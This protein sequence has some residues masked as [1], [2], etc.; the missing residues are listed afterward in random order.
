MSRKRAYIRLQ[1][2]SNR[3]TA[4]ADRLEK[5]HDAIDECTALADMVQ[6]RDQS[7]YTKLS[8]AVER[9][10]Q[11]S[12]NLSKMMSD[13]QEMSYLMDACVDDLEE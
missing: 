3:L 7:D 10:R 5:I 8:R 12:Y 11:A 2:I 1:S 13:L 9:L 6:G 4:E